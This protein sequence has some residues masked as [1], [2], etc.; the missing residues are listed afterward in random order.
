MRVW[1]PESKEYRNLGERRWVVDWQE[2]KP[3]CKAKDTTQENWEFDYDRDLIYHLNVA[4]NKAAALR[5]AEKMIA[6]GRNFFGAATVREQVVDWFVEEDRMGEW[7]D[8]SSEEV[9]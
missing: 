6:E 3:S 2:L 8:A 1:I 9:S 4:P 5:F 7:A